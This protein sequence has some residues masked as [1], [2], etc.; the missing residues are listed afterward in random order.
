[1]SFVLPNLEIAKRELVLKQ[2]CQLLGKKKLMFYHTFHWIFSCLCLAFGD[3]V[4]LQCVQRTVFRFFV[5]RF[6]HQYFNTFCSPHSA[7]FK[8]FTL[9]FPALVH[10]DFFSQGL[11]NQARVKLNIVRCPPVTTVLIRR[12]DLRYQLGFSV[13]NGIV[14][15]FHTHWLH[16]SLR[17]ASYPFVD[18]YGKGEVAVFSLLTNR[19]LYK[20]Y[21]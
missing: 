10:G 21:V 20:S 9:S 7:Y 15:R 19:T 13:Q 18:H 3:Q 8:H 16:F 11:K 14:S 12:P 17:E 2:M 1:M 6:P 4:L 5:F